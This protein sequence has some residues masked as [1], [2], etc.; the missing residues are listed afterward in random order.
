MRINAQSKAARFV[1]RVLVNGEPVVTA[2]EFDTNEGWV[3]CAIPKTTIQLAKK[4]VIEEPE[5]QFET[6][7]IIG[8]ITIVWSKDMPTQEEVEEEL[9]STLE[10]I[11]S[12]YSDRDEIAEFV[13]NLTQALAQ[14]VT[15]DILGDISETVAE[16]EPYDNMDDF[17]DP[18]DE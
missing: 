7:R 1:D 12:E 18:S 10:N 16:E 11:Y 8:D 15:E 17:S 5:A 3:D 6:K 9:L 2:V 4:S 14:T 13:I